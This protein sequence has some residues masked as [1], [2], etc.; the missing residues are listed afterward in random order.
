MLDSCLERDLDWCLRE[1]KRKCHGV[2]ER[3]KFGE[4]G[5]EEGLGEGTALRVFWGQKIL[6][7]AESRQ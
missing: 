1:W 7:G 5:A 2:E 6:L 3:G 4:G